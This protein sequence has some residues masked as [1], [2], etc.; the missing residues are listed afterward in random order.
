MKKKHPTARKL[1]FSRSSV[2][3]A[4][5]AIISSSINEEKTGHHLKAKPYSKAGAHFFQFC[6]EISFNKNTK[7][8]VF[9][10]KFFKEN[11]LQDHSFH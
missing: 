6:L 9:N 4:L 1:P 8:G 5:A 7:H 2:H 10:I 3:E 11:L